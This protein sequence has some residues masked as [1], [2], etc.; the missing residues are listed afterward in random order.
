[1]KENGRDEKETQTES[2]EKEIQ[3]SVMLLKRK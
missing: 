2:K 3:K 1:M